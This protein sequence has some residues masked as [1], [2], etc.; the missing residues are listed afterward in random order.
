M[1]SGDSAVYKAWM[2]DW[3]DL[4]KELCWLGAEEEG[5]KEECSKTDSQ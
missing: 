3:M 2:N 1:Y 4:L 5:K